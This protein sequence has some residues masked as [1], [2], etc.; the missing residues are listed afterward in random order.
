MRHSARHDRSAFVS[1]SL[2]AGHRGAASSLPAFRSP[3]RNGQRFFYARVRRL[4][5]AVA[6]ASAGLAV[7]DGQC[8]VRPRGSFFR[9][10]AS[11][12]L[13]VFSQVAEVATLGTISVARR[14]PWKTAIFLTLGAVRSLGKV[15]VRHHGSFDPD[16]RGNWLAEPMSWAGWQPGPREVAEGQD[17]IAAVR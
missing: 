8:V 15:P 3:C 10:L 7:R 11:G 5:R 17:E 2:V 4:D 1:P 9:N 6:M 14:D 13:Q 12:I 16:G